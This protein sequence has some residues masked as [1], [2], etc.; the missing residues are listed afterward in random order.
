MGTIVLTIPLGTY[1][2]AFFCVGWGWDAV[3]EGGED[4]GG[5]GGRGGG[6]GKVCY[7]SG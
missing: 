5:I 7:G 4:G 6:G 1:G 2:V 3:F